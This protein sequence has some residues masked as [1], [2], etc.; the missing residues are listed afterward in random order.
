M[1][2]IDLFV[3][4]GAFFHAS[5]IMRWIDLLMSCPTDL[6]VIRHAVD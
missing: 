2:W 5:C 3:E 4:S 1:R 6:K